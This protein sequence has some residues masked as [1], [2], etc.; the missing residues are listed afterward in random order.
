MIKI[1]KITVAANFN[2]FLLIQWETDAISEEELVD[3]RFSVHMSQSPQDDFLKINSDEDNIITLEYIYE[4]P[5]GI[6]FGTPLYFR[7]GITNTLTQEYVLSNI[8]S[9]LY[10]TPTDVVAEAIIYQYNYFLENILERP[11]MKL[12]IKKKFGPRCPS[13]WDEYSQEITRSSCPDC[14]DTGYQYGY[15]PPVN[16]RVSI[17]EPGFVEKL[18]IGSIVESQNAI[19]S[20][21]TSNYPLVY[22]RD[23]IVDEFNRRFVVLQSQPTT[24]DGRIYLRQL[25]Q[26]QLIPPTDIIYTISLGEVV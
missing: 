11:P 12:L 1:T 2:S 19:V 18:D 6:N 17:S 14:Y 25:L 5:Y 4:I 23:I 7:V 9:S 15:A 13:C 21:W 22:P 16:I 26:L 20:A 10:L 3:Y 8:F 24:K